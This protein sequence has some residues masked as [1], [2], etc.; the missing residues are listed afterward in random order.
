MKILLLSPPTIIFLSK[1]YK[2]NVDFKLLPIYYFVYVPLRT[3]DQYVAIAK[4]LIYRIIGKELNV[5]NWVV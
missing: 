1:R 5:K 2:Y 3:N 4:V